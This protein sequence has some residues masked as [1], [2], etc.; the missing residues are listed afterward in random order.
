MPGIK[1]LINKKTLIFIIDTKKISKQYIINKTGLSENKLEEWLDL[2]SPTLPT[3]NQAKKLAKCLSVPFACLYMDSK[4][5]RI[6][7]VPKIVNRRTISGI[8]SNDDSAINIAIIDTLQERDF[9][10]DLC[11]ELELQCVLFNSTAPESENVIDWVNYIRDIFDIKLDVQYQL[12]SGRKFYLYLRNQISS[13]GIFIKCFTGI[14]VE[15]IRGFAIF[16]GSL[17]IIGLN[18][19]DRPP[20]KSFSIIHELVHI[21][22]RESSMCNDMFKSDNS[23]NEEIF[24]NAVAGELLVP[25]Q[26]LMMIISQIDEE[27]RYQLDSIK[28][29]SSEF[30]VSREV[31]VRRLLDLGLISRS[32]Y[33][34]FYQQFETELEIEKIKRKTEAES[35]N[36]KPFAVNMAYKIFDRNSPSVCQ[37]LLYG[38]NENVLSKRDIAKHLGMNI[39]H[40]DRFLVEV[41]R[42]IK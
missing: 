8:M 40:V 24:C 31:I 38:Y 7:S 30:C 28:R 35:G 5:L 26:A 41:S 17:P 14:S 37:G 3:V 11:S 33:L 13:K 21:L 29:L 42:W 15:E 9:Y 4:D 6:K 19:N 23:V 20:A 16:D 27:N 39:K 12:N 2:S 25:R 10:F 18:D 1:A 22:K 32:E 36:N 34:S